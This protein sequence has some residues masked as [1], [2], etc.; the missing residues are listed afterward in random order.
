ME[1]GEIAHQIPFR[2]SWSSGPLEGAKRD[3]GG[4]VGGKWT[5]S[6]RRPRPGR[7]W[8]ARALHPARERV[9]LGVGAH[10]SKKG[11]TKSFGGQGLPGRLSRNSFRRLLA[12]IYQVLY[13]SVIPLPAVVSISSWSQLICC[14][15]L[16]AAVSLPPSPHLPPLPRPPRHIPAV[17]RT[18]RRG[19]EEA[20]GSLG[21]RWALSTAAAVS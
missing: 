19:R 21:A 15:R 14:D 11:K 3:W 6:P 7:A 9:R 13:G 10:S 18:R 4:G 8:G 16:S 5:P 17:L 20:P 12:E 1:G 2:P